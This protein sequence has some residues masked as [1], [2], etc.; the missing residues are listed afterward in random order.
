M[1]R[2]PATISS[3]LVFRLRDCFL[4][5]GCVLGAW[6]GSAYCDE[7]PLSAEQVKFFETKVRPLL[8]EHCFKCHGADQQK[9]GL[10]LDARGQM[11][12][13]GDSGPAIV[14]GKPEESLLLEAVR[15]ESFEMPPSRQLPEGDIKV[16]AT[17]IQAGA[18]WPGDDGKVAVRVEGKLFSETDLNWW[19]FQPVHKPDLP[20]I[21][22]ETWVRNEIDYFVARKHAQEHLTPAPEADRRV[23]IRRIYYDLI[24]LPPTIEEVDQFVA[25]EDP[26]AYERLVDRLLDRPE[27]GE[28]WARHW[29]DL[30]RYADSDGYRADGFR[31]EAWRYRDY[32]IQSFNEDKPYDRFV[33]EQLAGDE[34]FPDDPQAQIATGFLRHGIYE[35]NSRDARGQWDIMQNEVTDVTS[36]VFLGLGLQC[37]RCHDHKFDPLLQKDYFRLRAFFEPL[38]PHDDRPVATPEARAAYDKQ[39]AEYDAATREIQTEL[40][41]LEQKY[42]DAAAK[43]AIGR[44]PDEIQALVHKPQS[45]RTPGEEQVVAMVMR[46]VAWD[47]GRIDGRFKGEE[48]EKILELRRKL[49]AFN[50]KRPAP[51]PCPMTVTDVGPVA[52]PTLIPKKLVAVEPGFPTILQAEPAVIEPVSVSGTTG[53]RATLARWITDPQNPITPRVIT[54]RIWQY[55]FGRGLAENSSDFGRLGAPP[56]HPELLDLLTDRFVKGGWH[57]KNLHRLIVTSA[58]YRQAAVHPQF[59]AYNEQDPSNQWYWRGRTQRLD[60]EQIR[61]SI[62][63]VTGQLDLGRGGPGVL[64]DKPRRSIYTRTMR[65]SRDALLDAFDLPQ[66]FSSTSSRNTTTSPVQSLLLI[67]SQTMLRYATQ[68]EKRVRES[69]PVDQRTPEQLVEQIWRITLNRLPTAQEMA[70]ATQFVQSQMEEIQ[71]AI[72]PAVAP[73]LVTGKMPYRDGQ[74]ILFQPEKVAGT[75]AVSHDPQLDLDD[76]TVEIFFQPRSIYAS[77]DVRTLAAKWAGGTNPGWALGIT[78]KG[79]RRKP[80]TVVLQIAGKDRSGK[81]IEA[82]LFSDQ[83]VEM[84]K[85][86]YLAA[87]VKLAGKDHPG[88]VTFYLKDLSNDDEP[89]MV[90]EI[91]HSIVEGITCTEPLIFGSRGGKSGLFDGLLDDVRLSQGA[92]ARE[93]LLLTAEGAARQTVGYW[94]FEPMPGVFH[95]SLKQGLDIHELKKTHQQA[96]PQTSAWIDLCHVLLNSN[97]FLY[98]E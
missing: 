44:F 93:Q 52:P 36:D 42:L 20:R 16:L 63:A 4:V 37:A 56:T 79:S 71:N 45:E 96:S 80:Q 59:A 39:L 78:G 57:F 95:D 65:N 58:T 7:K 6:C 22:N 98:V 27:Y 88:S 19:S 70:S 11:L 82:A 40:K 35:Y 67:N 92:L 60:A 18:F 34:L 85:P 21:Q 8:A 31:P 90:A 38:M 43:S 83:H 5:A 10:R 86:Y 64:P 28:R 12:L 17:W 2:P 49:A 30:V 66:F 29:L 84:N 68:L 72:E 51:L 77:G 53:R 97:E 32:V 62:L 33:Q 48:K 74:S 54:N 91:P 81:R 23:L 94:Q 69:L 47:Q 9:G 24:G 1:Q 15:Y 25:D 76:F 89:V 14:P 61:D 13:G 50:A 46:Q 26:Y 3:K 87:C 75:F 73:D 41:T 55:H